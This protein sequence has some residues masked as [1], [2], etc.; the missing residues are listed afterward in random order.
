MLS[1]L[2]AV[3]VQAAPVVAP[4]SETRPSVVTNPDWIRRPSGA[5]LA[6]FYPQAAAYGEVEGVATISCNVNEAG[7]LVDC[8]AISESPGG[9]GFGEAAVNMSSIFKMRPATRDGKPVAGGVVRIPIR[10]SL[11]K[12]PPIAVPT[13]VVASRCYGFAAA[14]LEADPA[15]PHAR[16]AFFAMR[17]LVELKLAAQSLKPSELERRLLALRLEGVEQLKEQRF[18]KERQE[19]DAITDA[20]GSGAFEALVKEASDE[21]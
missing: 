8:I 7:S 13:L 16:L 14:R 17:T 21:R 5:D 18:A 1:V 4:P 12:G 15:V 19:C 3:L 10:F 2:F 20:L 9:M 11:P 6:R